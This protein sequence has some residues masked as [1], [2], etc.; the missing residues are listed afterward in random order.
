[1]DR[2]VENTNLTYKFLLWTFI[3][4][5]LLGFLYF[6]KVQE[7]SDFAY[8]TYALAILV[9]YM[10]IPASVVL[11]LNRTHLKKA[12]AQY[13]LRFKPNR[14]WLGAWFYP[15]AITLLTVMICLL[16]GWGRLDLDFSTYL[17][18]LA[19]QLTPEQLIQLKQ[20]LGQHET[21]RLLFL[22]IIQ[23]VI[24]GTTINALAAFGEELGWRGLL[25]HQL[26]GMGFWRTNLLIGLIWGLWHAPIIAAGYNF[27]QHPYSGILLMTLATIV[28]SPLIGYVRERSG[29]VIAAAI[30][31][32]VFNAVANLSIILIASTSNL[33]RS[34]LG[35][36]G[37]IGMLLL[38]AV[39]YV[40]YGLG[41]SPTTRLEK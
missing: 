23:E 3:P 16:F 8:S 29:S 19:S 28:L 13:G 18:S 41:R 40:L 37:I 33:F 30:F 26:R 22:I 25:Y 15:L 1:M 27:P 17:Q 35:V 36:A 11:L 20:Q 21:G 10:W 5:Y 6:Y 7:N 9:V 4:S 14:H 34:P 39:S 38:I 2:P 12:L 31:H 32:G 24:A